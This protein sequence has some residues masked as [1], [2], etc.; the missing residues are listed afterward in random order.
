MSRVGLLI[1]DRTHNPCIGR[2]S[3][4]HWTPREVLCFCLSLWR[5]CRLTSRVVSGVT[6]GGQALS[7]CCVSSVPGAEPGGSGRK[8][9][10]AWGWSP[11]HTSQRCPV[12]KAH[13]EARVGACAKL[14]SLILSGGH[15]AVLRTR[16][17]LPACP[18][19]LW[20]CRDDERGC[21]APS[22]L[23]DKGAGEDPRPEERPVEGKALSASH[24]S[25]PPYPGLLPSPVPQLP[26]VS[27]Q[28]L[29]L[30]V[31]VL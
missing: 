17:A 30:G 4:N 5:H 7:C 12:S 26:F 22:S 18:T 8:D 6:P 2:Q 27:L 21:M 16:P 20:R 10:V 11:G 14:G 15:R 31:G 28:T 9:G 29:G 23:S 25:L 13:V 1:W 19:S 3:L 24:F